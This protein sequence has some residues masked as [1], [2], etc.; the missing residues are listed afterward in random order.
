MNLTPGPSPKR[1]G[2]RPFPC[3]EGTGCRTL[4]IR[5]GGVRQPVRGWG[6][7]QLVRQAKAMR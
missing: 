6:L 4:A 3:R 7:G 1:R 2:E 5:N